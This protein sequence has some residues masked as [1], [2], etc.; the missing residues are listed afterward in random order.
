MWLVTIGPRVSF[1]ACPLGRELFSADPSSCF[2]VKGAIPMGHWIF[3]VL[4]HALRSTEI[5]LAGVEY[6]IEVPMALSCL[7]QSLAY[8]LQRTECNWA[9]RLFPCTVSLIYHG[10]FIW[11]SCC[12]LDGHTWLKQLIYGAVSVCYF[13]DIFGC[14]CLVVVVG[15]LSMCTYIIASISVPFALAFQPLR[16]LC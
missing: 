11:S 3:L 4:A 9:T 6:S 8:A 2:S 15:C 16:V 14:V 1:P 12:Y 5:F 10:P 7:F 13:W